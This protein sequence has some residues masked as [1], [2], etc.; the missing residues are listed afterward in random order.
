MTEKDIKLARRTH[1]EVQ[2]LIQLGRERRRTVKRPSKRID[3]MWREI[4]ICVDVE[5]DNNGKE[6]EADG[7]NMSHFLFPD[8]TIQG[9]KEDRIK[10]R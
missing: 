10:D 3:N 1:R 8:R 2:E 9:A 7:R 4:F 6:L 5:G